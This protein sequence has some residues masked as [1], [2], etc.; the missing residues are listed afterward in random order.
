MEDAP[1][2]EQICVLKEVDLHHHWT[3]FCSSSLNLADVDKLDVVGWFICGLPSFG[4]A[5]DGV[6]RAIGCDNI[7]EDG[8]ILLAG[9]GV[10]DIKPGAPPP[11]DDF[12]SSDPVLEEL[13]IPPGTKDPAKGC[14]A[15]TAKH[16][17]G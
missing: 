5:R 12:L 2:F 6:F 10:R 3:P 14:A 15:M 17:L 11:E 16:V 8:S 4:L 13:D 9:Q 1:I 7:L